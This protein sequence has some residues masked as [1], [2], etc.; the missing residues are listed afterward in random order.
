LLCVEFTDRNHGVAAGDWGKI[1]LTEDGGE[2]WVDVSLEEDILLYGIE[3][4]SSNEG[5]MAAETGALFHTLDGGKTWDKRESGEF[6]TFFG[7]S[8]DGKGNGVAVGVEGAVYH[9]SDGGNNWQHKFISRESLYNIVLVDG[10]GLAVGD[11]AEIYETR[12]SGMN[13]T[14]IKPPDLVRQ[15]WLRS[16]AVLGENKYMV[17]GAHGTAM[18]VEDS[19]IVGSRYE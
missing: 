19:T 13:W 1:L 6:Y 18:I 16:V 15:Y 2:N 12:D 9:T 7:I 5:W 17:F 10:R 11:A 14:R 3:F 4:V 8:F